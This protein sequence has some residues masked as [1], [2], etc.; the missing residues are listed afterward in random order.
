MSD[1]LSEQ[2]FIGRNFTFIARQW[3]HL[4]THRNYAEIIQTSKWQFNENYQ[5][6]S[7]ETLEWVEQ[8][9][10]KISKTKIMKRVDG[11]NRSQEQ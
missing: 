8:A 11:K 2:R 10:T 1:N 9:G 6:V 7:R 3:P 4:N 5:V